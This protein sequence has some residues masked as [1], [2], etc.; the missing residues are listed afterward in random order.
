MPSERAGVFYINGQ[1][2]HVR[3]P[4]RAMAVSRPPTDKPDWSRADAPRARPM[5][6]A[7]IAT[8]PLPMQIIW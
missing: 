3:I 6:S 4:D 7:L 8:K 5:E 2:T 1:F